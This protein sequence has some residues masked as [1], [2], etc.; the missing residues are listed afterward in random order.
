MKKNERD[1][2]TYGRLRNF[3]QKENDETDAKP[4]NFFY[5]S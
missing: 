5:S 1:Q 2:N 4:S 3:I